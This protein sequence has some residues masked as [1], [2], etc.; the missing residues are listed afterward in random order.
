MLKALADLL[1]LHRAFDY[2]QGTLESHLR[3]PVCV[4]CGACCEGNVPGTMIIEAINMVSTLMGRPSFKR[5]VDAAEDWLLEKHSFAA[6][7]RGMPLGVVPRDIHEE[8][9]A[10]SKSRC[11]F[12][13]EKRCIVH[14]CRP[15]VCMAF[16][17]TRQ[18]E[19]CGRPLGG[20]ETMTTR[21]TFDATELRKL[22]HTF[23]EKHGSRKPE[24]VIR[25]FVPA[26]LYR[27]AEPARFRAYVD[28]NRIAS[29][30]IIGSEM[31]TSL[32]WQPQVD[33]LRSGVSPDFVVHAYSTAEPERLLAEL[34]R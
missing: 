4:G 5:A 9:A 19:G 28:D 14:E 17:V 8:I 32:M 18:A 21:A 22:V 26:L 12:L 13:S 7:Y 31:D 24:W 3:V 23:K 27:A 16:G 30:K 34:R 11:P 1:T 33:A 25:G 29:A 20:N 2:A 10:V 15:L 6:I